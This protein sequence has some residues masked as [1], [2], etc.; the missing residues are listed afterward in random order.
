[1]GDVA[2]VAGILLLGGACGATSRGQRVT[3]GPLAARVVTSGRSRVAA[4]SP[5]CRSTWQARC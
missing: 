3:R 1:M 5:V 4:S 2:V